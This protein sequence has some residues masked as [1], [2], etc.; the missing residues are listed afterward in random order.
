[1]TGTSEDF[2][3]KT[4]PIFI[5]LITVVAFVG[6]ELI[7]VLFNFRSPIIHYN[8]FI[9]RVSKYLLLKWGQ[10]SMG[11]TAKAYISPTFTSICL[12]FS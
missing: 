12:Y 8:G 2:A 10:F 7:L 6:K 11:E 4:Y 1:M 9:Y 5:L 3:L